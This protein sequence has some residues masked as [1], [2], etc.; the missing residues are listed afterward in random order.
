MTSGISTLI[1]G[2]KVQ[3]VGFNFLFQRQLGLCEGLPG[4]GAVP[5]YG[6]G[7]EGEGGAGGAAPQDPEGEQGLPLCHYIDGVS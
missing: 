4:G 7:R 2:G 6:E 5:E 1:G 3:I